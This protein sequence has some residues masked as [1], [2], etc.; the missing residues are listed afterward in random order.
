MKGHVASVV[1]IL[2]DSHT[3]RAEREVIKKGLDEL[4]RWASVPVRSLVSSDSEISKIAAIYRVI[5]SYQSK[6]KIQRAFRSTTYPAKI[7]SIQRSFDGAVASFVSYSW[8]SSG[9]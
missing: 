3:D 1:A 7:I 8:F 6:P 2:S 4:Y 9:G 5:E